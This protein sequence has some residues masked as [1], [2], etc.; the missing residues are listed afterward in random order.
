M[1]TQNANRWPNCLGWS[2]TICR[3]RYEI[4]E[5][6]G[7]CALTRDSNALTGYRGERYCKLPGCFPE[8][9]SGAI[10]LIRAARRAAIWSPCIDS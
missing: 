5:N 6:G 2:V 7:I 1:T 8:T 4:H 9:E 10:T 3:T